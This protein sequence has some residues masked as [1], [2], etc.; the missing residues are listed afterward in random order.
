M[1]NVIKV[2]MRVI[3]NYVNNENEGDD[4]DNN[5]VDIDK[6]DVEGNGDVNEKACA[7]GDNKVTDDTFD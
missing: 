3:E 5:D 1:K 2:N 7:D 6:K 4:I